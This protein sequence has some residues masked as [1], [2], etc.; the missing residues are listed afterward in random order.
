MMQE[1]LNLVRNA[2][3]L[4]GIC[5]GVIPLVDYLNATVP[6]LTKVLS[7]YYKASAV[8]IWFFATLAATLGSIWFKV[9][10]VIFIFG[11]SLLPVL[12]VLSGAFLGGAVAVVKRMTF[13]NSARDTS[14]K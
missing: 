2:F 13:G 1:K 14:P 5:G 3:M 6:E 12:F 7:P 9:G 8:L 4:M 10:L 11:C